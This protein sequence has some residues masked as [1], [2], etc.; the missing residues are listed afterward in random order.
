MK[1]IEVIAKSSSENTITAIA[2]KFKARDFRTGREGED[3]RQAIRIL[4]TDENVQPALDALQTVLGAQSTAR[5][6]VF[7]IDATLPQPS[8]EKEKDQ[9]KAISSRESMYANVD[10]NTH[11]D[12]NFIIL[13]ILSTLV[14]AIGL[15]KNNV[16]VVI[17]A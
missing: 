17:G 16:A 12:S 3:G 5:I 1:L 7:P 9:D 11:L 8:S 2:E 15:V 10:K 6:I 4:L 13:V 14:A